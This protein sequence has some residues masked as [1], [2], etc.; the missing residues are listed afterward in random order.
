MKKRL[1]L[2]FL[3][4][5]FVLLGVGRELAKPGRVA[6]ARETQGLK[7]KPVSPPEA[8]Q[9]MENYG[10]L[11]L[12][13]IENQGQMDTQVRYYS[14]GR[15]PTLFFTS[16]EI[17]FS[18]PKAEELVD[19]PAELTEKNRYPR[20]LDTG[21]KK[22]SRPRLA[23]RL[24]PVGMRP[25][26]KLIGIEVQ[27]GKVNYYLGNNSA[28]WRTNIPTCRAVVYQEAYPGIDLK[29]YYSGRQLEYDIIVKPGADP[30]QVR[31]KYSGI[32]SLKVTKEG[33]LAIRLPDG[34]EVRQKK[35]LIYQ[36]IAGVRI[37]REGKFKI[38]QHGANHMYGFEVAAF[39]RQAPL[40]IDPAL[41]FSTYLGGGGEDEALAVAAYKGRVAVTGFTSSVN[42]PTKNYYQRI[43]QGGTA[44]AFISVFDANG[45]LVQSTYL[46]GGGFDEG[47]AIIWN[48][49]NSLV[50]AGQT[51][52]ANFPTANAFQPNYGGG[53][54]DGFIT[55]FVLLGNSMQL[56]NST[57]LGGSGY[58]RING[59]V[60]WTNRV[61][62]VGETESANFPFTDN[63]FQNSNRGFQ[64]AFVCDVRLGFQTEL[65][66]STYLGGSGND[67][68]TA[69]AENGNFG[70]ICVTG[71]TTS[72]N[73]PLLNAYQP[74][75]KPGASTQAFVTSLW[76]D[77][78]TLNFSTYLGGA[79]GDNVALAITTPF[80]PIGNSVGNSIYVTG[81]TSSASFPCTGNAFQKNLQGGEDAFVSVFDVGGA[82]PGP[83][84]WGATVVI[85]EPASSWQWQITPV[86]T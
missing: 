51:N 44:D 73:F 56:A 47:R 6:T 80:S 74:D 60:G 32:K 36:E 14:R 31:F 69:V 1:P 50:V 53:A 66:Y 76:Y 37:L 71:W 49:D 65:R 35:P 29:F 57:Y 39:D 34:G 28:N 46:G 18:L 52:S 48:A 62:V 77:L 27:K 40:V 12:Y 4:L 25:E 67:S 9:E 78:S 41:A 15:G 81:W 63:A 82:S 42:F 2:S 55:E 68:A 11:P 38:R 33:D 10:R 8:Q 58:D 79:N 23:L 3:V 86:Y 24:T 54:S 5:V 45:A 84:I 13:F 72:E 61:F 83:A 85:V 64:D 7:G 75:Y 17:C 21:E 20:H 26:A 43:F 30:R 70:G 22:N 16:K 19:I 59:I